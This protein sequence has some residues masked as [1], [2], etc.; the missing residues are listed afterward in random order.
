MGKCALKLENIADKC[1]LCLWEAL[2]TKIPYLVQEAVIVIRDVFRKYP[3]KYE[4]LLPE[5]C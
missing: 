1:V 5:I 2:R 4:G 3:S